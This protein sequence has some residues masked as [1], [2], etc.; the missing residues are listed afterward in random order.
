MNQRVARAMRAANRHYADGGDVQDNRSMF[1]RAADTAMDYAG[2]GLALGDLYTG[3][4]LSSLAGLN[5]FTSYGSVMEARDRALAGVPRDAKA[6]ATENINPMMAM[7]ALPSKIIKPNAPRI[8]W[9]GS[10]NDFEQFD[11][12]KFGSGAWT[13]K[14]KSTGATDPMFFLSN[15]RRHAG[16]YGPTMAFEVDGKLYDEDAVKMLE[17]WIDDINP[18]LDS[19]EAYRDVNDYMKKWDYDLYAGLN[20]DEYLNDVYRKAATGGY[21][22]ALVD[23]KDLMGPK[24]ERQL[25]ILVAGPNAKLKRRPDLEDLE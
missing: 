23:F 22:G 6:L 12:S 1:S 25:Q 8:F 24:G 15:S 9:H 2:R 7:A 20:V 14:W 11:A 13:N 5:P 19:S 3:G 21:D 17:R 4:V 18:S 10:P 16:G